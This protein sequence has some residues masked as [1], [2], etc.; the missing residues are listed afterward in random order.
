M[1]SKGILEGLQQNS[2]EVKNLG[3]TEVKSKRS[4]ALKNST[5]TKLNEL[6][7]FY[8]PVSTSL[9]EI[10]DEAICLLYKKKKEL[11]K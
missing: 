8:Y 11:S 2:K 6:K 3:T 9:E 10:V 4:Y 1:G 7:V 5:I